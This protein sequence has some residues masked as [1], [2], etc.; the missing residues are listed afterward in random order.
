[1]MIVDGPPGGHPPEV[2]A[3]ANFKMNEDL[4]PKSGLDPKTEVLLVPQMSGY[5]TVVLAKHRVSDSEKKLIDTLVA[6]AFENAR[7]ELAESEK[8]ANK[9]STDNSGE[10]TLPSVSD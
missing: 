8:K 6:T 1:M 2:L 4:I 9:I 7:D 10:L 3:L 5:R